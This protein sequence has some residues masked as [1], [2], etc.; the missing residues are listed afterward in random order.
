MTSLEPRSHRSVMADVA[1]LAGVSQQTVSRVLNGNPHVRAETRARVEEAVRKLDYRPNRVARALV[2]GRSRTLGVVSF[3]TTLFGPASTLSGIERAAHDAGYAVSIASLAEL[4]VVA[5]HRAIDRLREQ[6]V[7]GVLVIAPQEAAARALHRLPAGLPVV[8][9]E[10]GAQDDVPLVA[11]DQRAG[12]E[13]VTSHL[14]AHGHRTVWH[15]SGPPDWL[16]AQDR[17]RG[18]RDTLIASGAPVPPVLEGDWSA[19]S[20]HALAQRLPDDATAVFA[21]NDQMALGVLRALHELGRE[22]PGDVS[23]AGFDD[24]P[25]AAYF[26]PPLTTVRQRFD[27]VGRQALLALVAQLDGARRTGERTTIAPELV[28]RAS[29]ASPARSFSDPHATRAG[30]A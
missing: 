9:T 26:T 3:D 21:G 1:R 14:L 18:W 22:V 15:V 10:A 19:R 25:E 24:I 27:E 20:G 7:D 16:E 2:T 29:T 4:T 5:V 13:A 17:V 8:A 11:V 30:E 12:A 28:V 6:G 23:V